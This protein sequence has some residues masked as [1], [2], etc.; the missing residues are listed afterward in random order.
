VAF[1]GTGRPREHIL[2]DFDPSLHGRIDVVER[3]RNEDL[4]ALLGPHDVNVLPS[5]TEG[6]GMVLL[7]AM[8]RGVPSVATAVPGTT[9]FCRDGVNALLVRAADAAALHG[10]LE[11][12]VA[13]PALRARLSAAAVTTARDRTWPRVAARNLCL[14]E[15]HLADKRGA[16]SGRARARGDR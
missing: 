4:G 10:A 5:L 8:A 15:R 16:T 13:S 2:A 7:E 12:L 1:L 11:R 3:Y 9:E 6:F 14:Y